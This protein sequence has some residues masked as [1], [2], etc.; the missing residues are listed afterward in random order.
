MPN[1][2]SLSSD[3]DSTGSR[4]RHLLGVVFLL[5]GALVVRLFLLQ[6][7][8]SEHYRNLS[9]QNR[10]QPVRLEAPRGLIRDRN[11]EVLVDNRPSYT[12][13]LIRLLLD[14]AENTITKLRKIIEIDDATVEKVRTP[15][16]WYRDSVRLK[17][18]VD[19][20]VLSILE[21]NRY[22]F[23]GIE[24]QVEARRQYPHGRLASHLLGYMSEVNEDELTKLRASG[25]TV[26]D[27]VG[28]S[29]IER[30]C[31]Q[32]LRGQ[33]GVRYL[34]V[35][36]IGRTVRGFP[37]MTVEAQPGQDV[38]LT[39]DWRLQQATEEAFPDSLAGSVVVMTLQSGEILAMASQ[40][41]FDPA[42]FSSVRN[43]ALWQQLRNNPDH[44]M[45]NRAVQS[46]YP[47]SSTLKM[48]AAIAGLELGLIEAK[49]VKFPPC[50]GQ[51]EFGDRI[52]KCWQEEGHGSLNLIEALEQ[53]CDV[54]FYHLGASIG[55]ENWARYARLFGFEKW[56]GVDLHGEPVGLVPSREYYD[57]RYGSRNWAAGVVLNLAIGQGE[58][59]VTPL[60]MVRYI[61][62]IATGGRLLRPHLLKESSY[63]REIENG[64]QTEYADAISD[65][66]FQIIRSALLRVVHGAHGT[67]RLASVKGFYVAGKTGTSQNPHGDD[68]AWFV[69]FA[70]FENPSVAV[71]VIAENAGHGGAVAAPIFQRIIRA[72]FQLGGGPDRIAQARGDWETR[73]RKAR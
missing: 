54:F 16:R 36:A 55:L 65:T 33:D 14:E 57:Q 2:S 52:F 37:E 17:R 72:Y 15:R 71:A 18:D 9:D 8:D 45:L 50:K 34:E 62:A 11:G 49:S 73:D 7:A 42:F 48:V 12:I 31:E 21:E 41:D 4:I 26:G 44:P 30:M 66:T 68:H 35:N 47:P 69:G 29:G 20:D 22:D 27:F 70:P 43:P 1:V 51:L 64:D 58:I 6:I 32:I 38:Y 5:F 10:V 67:G 53:S 40:P 60:Q 61:G 56:T 46:Q 39:I 28:K 63:G 25:Y 23:P 24:I 3:T 59:A 13:A 19:F